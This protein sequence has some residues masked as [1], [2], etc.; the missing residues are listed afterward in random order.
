VQ[1]PVRVQ[2]EPEQELRE[3]VLPQRVPE[4]AQVLQEPER[5]LRVPEQ[6]L[7][8]REPPQRAR[9]LQVQELPQREQVQPAARAQIHQ[10]RIRRRISDC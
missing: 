7:Q 9:V 4:Q 10:C 3:Q 5:V 2:R 6:E 8:V 1:E